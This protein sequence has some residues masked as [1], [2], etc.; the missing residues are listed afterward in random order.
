MDLSSPNL[1]LVK[2]I[3]KDLP[4]VP[5]TNK[6]ARKLKFVPPPTIEHK[7]IAYVL[8]R[9]NGQVTKPPQIMEDPTIENSPCYTLPHCSK[10]ENPTPTKPSCHI[11]AAVTVT[12]NPPTP[13]NRGAEVDCYIK[14]QV[15]EP[16]ADKPSCHTAAAIKTITTNT[17]NPSC[18]TPVTPL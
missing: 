4:R 5:S 12:T 17:D 14:K 15:K 8:K 18:H 2:P 10:S 16:N 6:E 11:V 7:A 3:S 9:S 1:L 13:T